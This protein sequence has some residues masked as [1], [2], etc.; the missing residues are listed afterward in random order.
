ME[1]YIFFGVVCII[2][3]MLMFFDFFFKSCM[4]LPYLE[5]LKATGITVKFF[6]LNFYTTGFNRF[7]TRWS[8]KMPSIY[9]NSF[10]VGCYVTILLFPVAMC[11]V[12]ASLFSGS[13]P[14]ANGTTNNQVEDVARLEI[15]LPGVNLPLNEIGYYILALLICSVVHEAG[16]GIA[17]V[18]ED[19][20]VVG[21][22]LS[23]MFIVPI[24]FTEIDTDQLQT[25]KLWKK[26][27]IYSAGIWNNLLLAGWSYIIL[28]LLPILFS[29]I[30]DTNEAIFI[31]KIKSKAPIRGE[32]GLYVGDSITQI[33]GCA[34]KNEE[35]WLRCLS[36]TIHHH[37]AYCVSEDFVHNNEESIHEVDHQK[38]GIHSCCPTNPALN[39]FENFDVERLPQYV[40]LNIRSTVEAA[41][42]YC[43]KSRCDEHS[44][45]CIKAILPN[46]TTI[47][48]MKRKNR[49]KDLVYYGH[50]YDFLRNVEISEFTPKTK[51][52]EP[53]FGD[54]IALL[55]K[56]LA[57]FSSGLAI[58]NV[59]P[60]YGLDGQFLVNALIANLPAGSFDKNRK[61][62]ISFSINLVGSVTLFLAIFKI[63][64]TTFV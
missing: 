61:E 52:F 35:D 3:G 37:P 2:Y 45:T 28:L 11:L 46:T 27:K 7:I 42:D 40:C 23:L 38:D 56:Y 9:R 6:R 54:A 18:L 16:H 15:L 22:G 25:A 14:T 21:F 47:I 60:C 44:H 26:M 57:V 59:V 51:F 24:A 50:P 36:D 29:P 48:H 4:M 41:R 34:V 30:Y 12:V 58:V 39:C 43:H 20:P 5:F 17:A 64:Y 1:I 53:W 55:L 63:I 10:M 62:V 8:S 13:A 33:N 32:N 19:V 31:T 49:T